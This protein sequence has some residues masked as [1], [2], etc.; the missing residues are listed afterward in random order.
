[1]PLLL[2]DMTAAPEPSGAS[3]IISRSDVP[4]LEIQDQKLSPSMAGKRIDG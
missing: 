1:M 2:A 3:W 4:P